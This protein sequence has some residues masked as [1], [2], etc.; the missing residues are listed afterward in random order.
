MRVTLEKILLVSEILKALIPGSETYLSP[1]P[2]G[3]FHC[4]QEE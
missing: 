2:Y 1:H 4:E 3:V